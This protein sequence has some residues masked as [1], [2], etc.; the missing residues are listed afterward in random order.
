MWLFLNL[1]LSKHME[2][3]PKNPKN[4]RKVWCSIHVQA[5]RL[6][7]S[8]KCRGNLKLRHLVEAS[9]MLTDLSLA[10]DTQKDFK[11]LSCIMLHYLALVEAT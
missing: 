7:N 5:R 3:K 1:V 11:L 4:T 6:G 9:G 8:S 2:M 10:L